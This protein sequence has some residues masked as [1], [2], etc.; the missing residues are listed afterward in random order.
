M[1][2][3]FNDL[4]GSCVTVFLYATVGTIGYKAGLHLWDKIEIKLNK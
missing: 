3:N 1:L 4:C 2:R